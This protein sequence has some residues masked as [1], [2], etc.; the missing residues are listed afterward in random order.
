MDFS[1]TLF[2]Q[3]NVSPGCL[4]DLAV[5]KMTDHFVVTQLIT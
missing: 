4:L 2:I 3:N 1:A 5:M